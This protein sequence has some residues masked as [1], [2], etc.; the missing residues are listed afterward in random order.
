MEKNE[1]SLKDPWENTHALWEPRRREE[2]GA[3]RIW[4]ND[5]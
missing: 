5:S 1:Q 2:D 4:T 3:E